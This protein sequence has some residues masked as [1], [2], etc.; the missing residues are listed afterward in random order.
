[1]LKLLIGNRAYSSWSLRGWLACRQAGLPFA[2]ELIPLYEGDWETR[3]LAPDM[4]VS[5]GRLPVL[6]DG[7][8]AAWNALGI[9]DHLER[10]A[11]GGRFWPDAPAAR[12][13]IYSIAAEVQSSY[14]AL[15]RHCPMNTRRH[16]PD[17]AIPPEV[18]ADV[19][20]IDQ[21][22]NEAVDRFGGPWLAGPDYGGADIMFAPI[23]SR[24]TTYDIFLSPTA[25][26]Y[27]E[28]AMTHPWMVEW[29]RAAGDEP[30]IMPGNERQ[31]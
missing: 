24:F 7:G 4:A 19:S 21:L 5:G 27:R 3:R 20:R 18:E 22:W 8:M 6:W 12:A 26:T 17:Y 15:R 14:A 16:Y 9:I 13:F 2:E 28:R 11:G 31:A 29:M 30:W 1:M 10:I 25:D 23:A